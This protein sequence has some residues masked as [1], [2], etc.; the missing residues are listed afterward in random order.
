[1]PLLLCVQMSKN[2]RKTYKSKENES[3]EP[4]DVVEQLHDEEVEAVAAAPA[5]SPASS[6]G[7]PD[8]MARMMAMMEGLALQVNTL[9]AEKAVAAP[10]NGSDSPAQ[11]ST[12]R[13][14]EL[15]AKMEEMTLK[16]AEE[17]AV[18]RAHVE[19]AQ[20]QAAAIQKQQEEERAAAKAALVASIFCGCS[21][22]TNICGKGPCK[23]FTGGKGCT[24]RC[25]CRAVS[26]ICCNDATAGVSARKKR[27]E[28]AATPPSK[29]M[30][31]AQLAAMEA[32]EKAIQSVT[33]AQQYAGDA[34]FAVPFSHFSYW[35]LYAFMRR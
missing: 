31:L 2:R 29:A 5:P 23:C 8:M 6:S 24:A 4:D 12:P 26:S 15:Q 1:M 19:A 30:L 27:Q 18:A 25:G 13:E 3:A 14:M 21:K 17:M 34:T 9:K 33:R 22:G 32:E 35:F 16:Q 20:K 7:A 11:P 10:A 28:L